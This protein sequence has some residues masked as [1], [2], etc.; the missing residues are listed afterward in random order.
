MFTKGIA[1][2]PALS[3]RLYTPECAVS[4]VSRGHRREHVLSR[5]QW[6]GAAEVGLFVSPLT[7]LLVRG[8]HCFLGISTPLLSWAHCVSSFSKEAELKGPGSKTTT[9]LVQISRCSTREAEVACVCFRSNVYGP[10]FQSNTLLFS[11][12]DFFLTSC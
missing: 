12:Y 11:D 10:G 7:A 1:C 6:F 9:A 3:K 8:L 4:P 5:T 2:F